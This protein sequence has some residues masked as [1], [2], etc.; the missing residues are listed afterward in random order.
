MAREMF[1]FRRMVPLAI[2]YQVAPLFPRGVS[3]GFCA[4]LPLE[5]YR[6]WESEDGIAFL[7]AS[8]V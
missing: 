1:L 5:G 2:G 3:C 8:G 6:D 4:C 7:S